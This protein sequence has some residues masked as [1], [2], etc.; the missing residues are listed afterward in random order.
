[1]SRHQANR[2]RNYG[3]RQHE[4][5]EREVPPVDWQSAAEPAEPAEPE[6]AR[7][8]RSWMEGSRPLPLGDLMAHPR[9]RWTA[10]R[11]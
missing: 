10:G 4:I 1:M 3:R 6:W 5:H 9:W 7:V 11:G 2:R 8:E